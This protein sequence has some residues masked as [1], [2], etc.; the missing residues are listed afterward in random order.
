MSKN[1]YL[2]QEITHF[3]DD[4]AAAVKVIATDLDPSLNDLENT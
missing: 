3:M 2:P 4:K 1:R